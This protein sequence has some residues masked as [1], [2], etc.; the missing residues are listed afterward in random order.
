L[1]CVDFVKEYLTWWQKKK[2]FEMEVK[3]ESKNLVKEGANSPTMT[4]S[5]FLINMPKIMKTM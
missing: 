2:A 5:T 3:D 1:E 4:N